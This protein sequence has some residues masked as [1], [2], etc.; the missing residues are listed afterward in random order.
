MR[1]VSPP[2]LGDPLNMLE[3][4]ATCRVHE[5]ARALACSSKR[6]RRRGFGI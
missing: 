2:K 5:N 1:S 6:M 4:S 3:Q